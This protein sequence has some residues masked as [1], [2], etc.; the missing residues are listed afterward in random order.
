MSW[1]TASKMRNPRPG[2]RRRDRGRRSRLQCRHRAATDRP[3]SRAAD[4]DLSFEELC[5]QTPAAII[6][7]ANA[8]DFSLL[9]YTSGTTS[10]PKG[11]PRRHRSERA[12]AVAHVAQNLYRQS[13]C[14]LGVMPLYHTRACVRC[15]PWR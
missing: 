13:E 3:R 5:S 14:T 2:L 11:V 8:E 6:L 4:S 7:Q 9:L 15:C 1:A 12:A 10:K